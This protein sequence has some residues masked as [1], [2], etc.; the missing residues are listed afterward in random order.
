MAVGITVNVTVSSSGHRLCVATC[1]TP[2]ALS[3]DLG[4]IGVGNVVVLINLC[5]RF[6]VNT[7]P[8][9]ENM[10]QGTL[11]TKLTITLLEVL[12]RCAISR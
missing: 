10:S 2:T 9:G 12:A 7:S 4:A 6:G 3:V 5:Q 8:I 11:H 1:T